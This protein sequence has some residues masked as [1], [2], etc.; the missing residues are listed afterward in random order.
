MS[1]TTSPFG[2]PVGCADGKYFTGEVKKAP[3]AKERIL[4]V[5]F[6]PFRGR[7]HNGSETLVRALQRTGLRGATVEVAIL[8]VVWSSVEQV[9]MP[10]L[11]S[12][13]PTLVLAIGEGKPAQVALERTARNARSGV[14]ERGAAPEN[15]WVEMDGPDVVNA[16]FRYRFRRPKALTLPLV[17]SED[18]GDFLC[19]A[20]LYRCLEM[21]INRVGFVHVPPQ[22]LAEASAYEAQLLPFLVSLIEHNSNAETGDSPQF[23][24]RRP[25]VSV[26]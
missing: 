23:D 15:G 1:N 22:E 24:A 3:P 11:R 6:A 25:R 10:K 21:P 8:P 5:G 7:L 14:D 12:F 13:G 2:D 16:R 26:G 17:L 18:A 20:T 4:L 19:N 9:L